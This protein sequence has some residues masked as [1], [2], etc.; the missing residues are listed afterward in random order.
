MPFRRT[1]SYPT[2]N[3][4]G[5][6]ESMDIP[7]AESGPSDTQNMSNHNFR[8]SILRTQTEPSLVQSSEVEK[9]G[10]R[11]DLL[12]QALVLSGLEY[13]SE[14]VQSALWTSLARSRVTIEHHPQPQGQHKKRTWPLPSCFFIVYVCSIGDGFERPPV[15]SSLVSYLTG[16]TENV[17]RSVD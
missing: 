7:A 16:F 17:L 12:P 6:R 10:R 3:D 13:A 11:A 4:T 8:L 5:L 14:Q 1:S 2:T 9:D 15:H